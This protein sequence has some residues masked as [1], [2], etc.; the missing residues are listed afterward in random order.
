MFSRT[1]K[2][3]P[4]EKYAKRNQNHS[5]APRFFDIVSNLFSRKKIMSYNR[6]GELR[7]VQTEN[8][9]GDFLSRHHASIVAGKKFA[10]AKPEHINRKITSLLFDSFAYFVFCRWKI[11]L[12]CV[13]SAGFSDGFRGIFAAK[14]MIHCVRF[15][16]LF[17]WTSCL[18]RSVAQTQ[19]ESFTHLEWI[20]CWRTHLSRTFL[21]K[22]LAENEKQT[23]Q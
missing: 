10:E 13:M 2:L 6:E 3:E 8:S 15:D 23:L 17:T 20:V 11:D 1:H 21:N 4:P 18:L 19:L 12:G 9:R 14:N 5:R 16:R 22:H 7:D